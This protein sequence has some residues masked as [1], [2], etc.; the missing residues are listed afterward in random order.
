MNKGIQALGLEKLPHPTTP[1]KKT[2]AATSP[3]SFQDVFE[4]E[5]KAQENLKVSKHAEKRLHS[6]DVNVSAT[7][8]K[9]IAEKVQEAKAKGVTDSIVL[10]DKAAL[11]VSAKN[12]TVITAMSRTEAAQH[13]FTNINGTIVI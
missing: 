7:E 2:E 3:L 4:Q 12:H 11:V 1:R 13:V 6:R 9:Q 8:W 10:T 5:L